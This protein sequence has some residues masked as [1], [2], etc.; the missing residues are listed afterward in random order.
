MKTVKMPGFVAEASLYKTCEHYRTAGTPN[1]LVGRPGVLSQLQDDTIWT[2]DKVCEA[3]GCTVSGFQCNCGLRPNPRKVEC[4]L[5]G[6][7]T[8]K[9]AV[10]A[11][12]GVRN[13]I[14]SGQRA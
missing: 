14:S 11:G 8:K 2:T 5:N 10:F 7:P 13:A 12:G 4:I 1:D 9:V 3:C 6:G